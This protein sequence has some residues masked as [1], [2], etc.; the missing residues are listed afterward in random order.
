MCYLYWEWIKR[1][2]SMPIRGSTKGSLHSH[3][4]DSN[5][6][7]KILPSVPR[8]VRSRFPLCSGE[9]GGTL[10]Q[11]TQKRQIFVVSGHSQSLQVTDLYKSFPLICQQQ[12]RLNYKRRVY[13][14]HTKGAP[15]VPSS[16]NKGGCATGPYRTSATLGHTTKIRSQSNST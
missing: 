15:R 12:P 7:V 13:S 5:S 10:L 3:C 2:F 6:L 1:A 16:C 8:N 4:M 11:G 9:G 14:A